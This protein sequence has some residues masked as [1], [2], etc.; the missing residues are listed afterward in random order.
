[1]LQL[2]EVRYGLNKR[3]YIENLEQEIPPFVTR[4]AKSTA[5]ERKRDI[6]NVL[7]KKHQSRQ[8][9]LY[10]QRHKC[11]QNISHKVSHLE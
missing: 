11:H 2:R 9:I 7:M 3:I 1:M 8:R 4:S 6:G 5:I 10:H